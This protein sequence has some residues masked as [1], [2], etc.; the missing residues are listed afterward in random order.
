MAGRGEHRVRGAFVLM[1]VAIAFVLLVGAAL[2]GRSLMH[3]QAVDAGFDG[4]AVLTARVTLNFSRYNTRALSLAFYDGLMRR[5]SATP[6]LGNAAVASTL[7][8]NNA[9]S[10]SQRQRARDSR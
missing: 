5:L 6:G 8:L 4:H 3:L 1:Q 7:P 10:R 9:G 2:V